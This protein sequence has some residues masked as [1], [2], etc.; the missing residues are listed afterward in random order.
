MKNKLISAFVAAAMALTLMPTA[1]LPV[2]A[3]ATGAKA[4]TLGTSGIIARDHIYYGNNGSD[5]SWRVLSLTGN[6]GTYDVAGASPMFLISENALTG[7]SV[8][9]EPHDNIEQRADGKWY[10]KNTDILANTYQGSDA[11]AWCKDFAGIEGASVNDAFTAAELSAALATTKSDSVY[12]PFFAAANNILSGDKVFFLSAEEADTYFD[13]YDDRM[14]NGGTVGWWLRSPYAVN[15]EYAS[16]VPEDGRARNN[17][18]D[19][20]WAARPAFNLN[21]NNVLFSSAAVGGKSSTGMDSGLTAVPTTTPT[22]WK[23]TLKDSGHTLATATTSDL[24]TA[25]STISV[26]YTGATTGTTLSGML[27]S[28]TNTDE[29]LYYGNLASNITQSGTVDVVLPSDFDSNTMTLKLFTETLSANSPTDYASDLVELEYVNPVVSVKVGSNTDYYTSFE[30][31]W[32]A[33]ITAGGTELS[34][35]E[36]TLLENVTATSDGS[37]TDTSFGIG[38]CFYGEQAIFVPSGKYITLDLNDKSLDR[39]LSSAE[40]KTIG[41]VIVNQGVLNITDNGALGIGTIKGGNSEI[42][43][44]GICN[45][46]GAVLTV[47]GG[48][49]TGNKS[50]NNEYSGGGGIYNCGTLKITGGSITGNI[51]SGDGGGIWSDS[52]FTMTGGSITANTSTG[53]GGGVYINSNSATVGGTANISGNHKGMDTTA[54][55][56]N[57]NVYLPTAKF[58]NVSQTAPLEISSSIGISTSSTPTVATPIAISGNNNANYSAYFHSDNAAY[59]VRN[60]GMDD[61]QVLK[62]YPTP[63][64][65][66]APTNLVWDSDVPAKATWNAVTNAD[67]YTVQLIRNSMYCGDAVTTTST[68]YDFLSAIVAAGTDI[69]IYIFEVT[70]VSDNLSYSD[71][72][73]VISG[74]YRHHPLIISIDTQPTNTDVTEGSITESLTASATVSNYS[75][76][77][78]Q[79]FSCTNDT[80]VGAADIS[81]E[82]SASFGIP[83]TL[84][85][86]T[87][88]YFCRMSY[89]G[90]VSVDS[91]VVAVT[92]S[93]APVAPTIT[94]DIL[95]NGT[96]GT[97]Y[98]QTLQATGDAT[99]TWSLKAGSA[100]PTGLTLS[101]AGLISGEPTTTGSTSFMVVASNGVN[102][103]AE[104]EFSIAI[105]AA[106]IIPPAAPAGGSPAVIPANTAGKGRSTSKAYR[107]TKGMDGKWKSTSDEGLEFTANGELADVIRVKVDGKIIN[108]DKDYTIKSGSTIITLTPEFLKTLSS[109]KHTLTV[110]YKDGT[111]TTDFKVIQ[112][113]DVATGAGLISE[114]EQI[115]TV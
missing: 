114:E 37:S 97:A 43:G 3:G 104:R 109:G 1:A 47:S 51:T 28:K 71:S 16:V 93:A 20:C 58:L 35:V 21:T 23:L 110:V 115:P 54:A 77:N 55:D 44:G 90:A 39:G 59:A 25:G 9:F 108:L 42:S 66:S 79:W 24:M 61:N 92:V 83:A 46:A 100:L 5:I 6:G 22:E 70:A 91:N 14:A 7:E 95:Q 69:D 87:Y 102:P 52:A 19:D 78:Y 30:T 84:T 15:T 56:Y 89:P 64:R 48:C 82:T 105:E 49:I 75:T 96:V 103:D 8:Q 13:N 29:V 11:Q 98:S 31:G 73:P 85:M 40:A 18:V 60:I 99:I 101:T 26:S 107:F 12:S 4:I 53:D 27:V 50:I 86:G 72:I 65:L 76:P 68:C 36:V 74:E 2:S 112:Y 33:A 32:R 106:P 38:E 62:L 67:R 10:R 41:M 34:P 63:T 81:G 113:E 111:V 45:D 57:N 17:R 80:K 88:Y 94:T